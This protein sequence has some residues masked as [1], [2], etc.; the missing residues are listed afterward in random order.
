MLGQNRERNG[1]NVLSSAPSTHHVLWRFETSDTV[2]AAPV[3]YQNIV[4]AVSSDCRLVALDA[5]TGDF[6]WESVP[7]TTH[8]G[9]T[10]ISPAVNEDTVFLGMGSTGQGKIY[11][12][13]RL[14]GQILWQYDAVDGIGTSPLYYQG[15]LF[16][17]LWNTTVLALRADTGEL[18]WSRE[19]GGANKEASAM[20][21]DGK[22]YVPTYNGTLMIMDPDTGERFSTIDFQ[23]SVLTPVASG[24]RLYQALRVS[25]LNTDSI[26]AIDRQTGSILWGDHIGVYNSSRPV[27]GYN[28][29]FV[30]GDALHAFDSASGSVLWRVPGSV[31]QTPALADGMLFVSKHYSLAA[32]EADSGDV[33]WSYPLGYTVSSPVVADAKV[34]IGSQNQV[35]CFYAHEHDLSAGAADVPFPVDPGETIA[36]SMGVNNEGLSD[37]VN[38]RVDFFANDTLVESKSIP[39]LASMASATLSFRWT[40][41]LIKQNINIRFKVVPATGEGALENNTVDQD[42]PVGGALRAVP[43]AYSTIGQALE[44]AFPGDTIEIAPGTYIEDIVVNKAHLTVKGGAGATPVIKGNGQYP[45]VVNE[46]GSR[47]ENLRIEGGSAGISINSSHNTLVELAFSD[48]TEAIVLGHQAEEN[49]LENIEISNFS[50]AGIRVSSGASQTVLENCHI[51]YG[52]GV[53]VLL[54]GTGNKVVNCDIYNNLGNGLSVTGAEDV[55]IRE[56]RIH[57]NGGYGISL[58]QSY[59][60]NVNRP[61]IRDCTISHNRGGISMADTVDAV[62][63]GNRIEENQLNFGVFTRYVHDIDTS[64][65]INGNPLYYLKNQADVT[66]DGMAQP[67]GFLALINCHNV[68]VSQGSFSGNYQGLLLVDSDHVSVTASEFSGNDTGVFLTG[69]HENELV[70]CSIHDNG[71]GIDFADN[72]RSNL[73]HGGD[74]FRNARE[75]I[76]YGTNTGPNEVLNTAIFENRFG[77]YIDAWAGN[78]ISFC[79]IYS[80]TTGI[81]ADNSFDGKIRHCTVFNNRED[82]IYLNATQN[83]VVTGNTL[84]GNNRYGIFCAWAPNEVS[85]SIIWRNGQ[86]IGGEGARITYCAVQEPVEGDGNITDDP[87]LWAPEKEDFRLRPESP[88]IDG[89]N[90]SPVATLMFDGDGDGMAYPDMGAY[91]FPG[92]PDYFAMTLGNVWVYIDPEVSATETWVQTVAELD[93]TRFDF[94][95][96]VIEATQN[97]QLESREWYQRVPGKVLLWGMED[98]S[99]MFIR[100]SQG[101]EIYWESMQVGETRFT[102]A[103]AA[104]ASYP[105]ILVDI[106]MR[107]TVVA[108]QQIAAMD[109]AY[110][111]LK[112]QYDFQIGGEGNDETLTSFQWVSPQ[113]GVLQVDNGT[114]YQRLNSYAIGG[115]FITSE[116]DMDGDG[117]ADLAEISIHGSSPQMMDSDRDGCPDRV[118]VL[119][120]RDPSTREDR[121][122][123]DIN[124]DCYVDHRDAIWSLNV[125]VGRH[126]E[127]PPAMENE[128]TGD[129]KI[130]VEEGIFPLQQ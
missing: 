26:K 41:P 18:L 27:V 55:Q 13:N 83:Y 108:H 11:A 116:S 38:V 93:R 39:A 104:I 49:S 110:D 15:K 40:A 4:Y 57:D 97:H 98:D 121:M 16:V 66:I 103:K 78:R 10:G 35:Y 105:D 92:L 106:S 67:M 88:C 86:N 126:N 2:V 56:T 62:L 1:F 19:T 64:N 70:D 94:P 72:T 89:G 77:V 14:T 43:S 5:D 71:T 80:N 119:A 21:A 6:I 7:D 44:A 101:L 85:N 79:R 75:G 9:Q 32:L 117:L 68:R 91:E 42:V 36:V 48:N 17:T 100:F 8:C 73:V 53:G 111:A 130:G 90:P 129:G 54:Q 69:S 33:I 58:Y 107:A 128:I 37:E 50:Q 63:R 30:G 28:T 3:V 113:L 102:P 118:E 46:D 25:N 123:G 114:G 109:T 51:R 120:N 82:G 87:G 84:F 112:I 61:E 20:I 76:L 74:I 23:G 34:Y 31:E 115:G 125:F 24:A 60:G 59:P 29:V 124:E 52:E 45:L 96:L 22:L 12:L 65:T 95:T 127:T 47:W 81:Y 99:G 122:P